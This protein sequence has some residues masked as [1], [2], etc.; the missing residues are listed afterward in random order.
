M[1]PERAQGGNDMTHRRPYH[2][3]YTLAD[4]F[5]VAT[6]RLRADESVVAATIA[7]TYAAQWAQAKEGRHANH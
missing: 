2:V 4:R 5:L 7:L 1:A 3:R 6:Q